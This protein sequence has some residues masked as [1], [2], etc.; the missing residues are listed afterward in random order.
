MDFDPCSPWH[1]KS[2]IGVHRENSPYRVGPTFGSDHWAVV[3]WHEWGPIFIPSGFSAGGVDGEMEMSSG[4]SVIP[5]LPWTVRA[6]ICWILGGPMS[7][8][9]TIGCGPNSRRLGVMSGWHDPCHPLHRP[10]GVALW[11]TYCVIVPVI[12]RVD[13]ALLCQ[14]LRSCES[15]IVHAFSLVYKTHL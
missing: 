5:A 14:V 4:H 11:E 8:F 15:M 12:F 13:P 3:F 7:H 6:I 10:G 2:S 9:I 1:D